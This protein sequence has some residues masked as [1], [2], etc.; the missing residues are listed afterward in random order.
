MLGSTQDPFP[1]TAQ[2][3]ADSV[4]ERQQHATVEGVSQRMDM[5]E[6]Q[7]ANAHEQM[8]RLIGMY[9]TLRG[10]FDQFQRQRIIEL[11]AA[12]NNGPTVKL[13]DGAID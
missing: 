5:L 10:E 4:K 11:T 8:R 1:M 6:Q 9:G 12:V 13:D 3:V 7:L 2:D